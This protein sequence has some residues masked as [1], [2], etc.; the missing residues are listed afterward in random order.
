MAIEMEPIGFAYTDE[1]TVPRHWTVSGVAGNLVIDEKYVAGLQGIEAGQRIVV[2]FH[3]HKSSTFT[4]DLLVQTP[5]HG[6][7][8]SG[9]FRICSNR[10]PNPIGLS[11][12]EVTGLDGN[13]ISVKGIDMLDG[14]PILDIKPHVED[15]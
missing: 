4:P 8:E 10:R 3:F 11:V 1:E 15:S 2:L 13:V 6:R 9:V 5:Y 12:L 7:H 14:T